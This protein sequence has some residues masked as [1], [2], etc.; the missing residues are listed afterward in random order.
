[1][2]EFDCGATWMKGWGLGW[3]SI[4]GGKTVKGRCDDFEMMRSTDQ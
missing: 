3:C 2:D 1:M 4:G